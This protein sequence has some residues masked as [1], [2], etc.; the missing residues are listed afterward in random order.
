MDYSL[1]NSITDNTNL[2]CFKKDLKKY[3]LAV[4]FFIRSGFVLDLI[5]PN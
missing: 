4:F 5:N 2:D 3:L 1:P